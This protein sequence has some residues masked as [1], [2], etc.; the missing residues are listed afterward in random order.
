M[1]VYAKPTFAHGVKE[2][3]E[4][5]LRWINHLA[6]IASPSKERKVSSLAQIAIQFKE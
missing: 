1:A 5:E 2:S 3:L 4:G 6:Q